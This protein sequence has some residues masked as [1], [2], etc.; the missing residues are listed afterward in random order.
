MKSIDILNKVS[1]KLF[2]EGSSP[3]WYNNQNVS[4]KINSSTFDEIL[5]NEI[6]E[7]LDIFYNDKIP[8]YRKS[9]L[10]NEVYKDKLNYN[11]NMNAHRALSAYLDD[12]NSYRNFPLTIKNIIDKLN[13]EKY[14]D[15]SLDDITNRVLKYHRCY[16]WNN[17]PNYGHTTI[18]VYA[19]NK[20]DSDKYKLFDSTINLNDL[21]NFDYDNVPSRFVSWENHCN[22]FIL[23]EYLQF[24]EEASIL[25]KHKINN[26]GNLFYVAKAYGDG[27]GFDILSINPNTGKEKLVEVKSGSGSSFTLTN[28]EYNVMK[29]CHLND[30]EYYIYF[31]KLNEYDNKLTVEE[32]FYDPTIDKLVS[33][34][35]KYY[36]LHQRCCEYENPTS[37]PSE[38][39]TYCLEEDFEYEKNHTKCL[40]KDNN[41]VKMDV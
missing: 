7:Y 8:T 9:L 19:N 12:L 6:V 18:D 31:Y 15:Q 40:K 13:I 17:N 21:I 30:A 20:I 38:K 26:E 32:Y 10:L 39:I 4:E 41:S 2:E 29:N 28:N 5:K 37:E 1:L 25:S 22:L 36:N 23:S 33:N 11:S 24:L 14:K 35:G 3:S 27:F 34:D 16:K